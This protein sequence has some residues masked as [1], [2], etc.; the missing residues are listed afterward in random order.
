MHLALGL[1]EEQ[2]IQIEVGLGEAHVLGALAPTLERGLAIESAVRCVVIFALDPGPE[3][4]IERL[5]ALRILGYQPG[6]QLC[7]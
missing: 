7:A 1:E 2:I 4:T 6:E 3:A 5:E